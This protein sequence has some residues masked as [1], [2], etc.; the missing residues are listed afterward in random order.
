M[1]KVALLFVLTFA[2]ATS[3]F[4]SPNLQES[5]IT[6]TNQSNVQEDKTGPVITPQV[7]DPLFNTTLAGTNSTSIFNVAGGYG[8][9]KVFIK[10]TGTSTITATMEHTD[11]K[12]IYF[13]KSI[14]PG[15]SLDWRSFTD[16][17]Q[18]VKGGQYV[19]TYR[20]GGKNMSSQAW[21]LSAT[22]NNEL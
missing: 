20:A 7:V 14:A 9:V 12:K 17:P 16:T 13:S 15:S 10:N 8:H 4:A 19:I 3:V 18:G 11:S 2:L 22:N 21:G 1:K 5:P 6:N